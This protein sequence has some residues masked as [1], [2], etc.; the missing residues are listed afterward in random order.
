MVA[1][2]GIAAYWFLVVVAGWVLLDPVPLAWNPVERL[3]ASLLLGLIV[4][5]SVSFLLGLAI[6]ITPVT[7]LVAP[8]AIAVLGTLTRPGAWVRHFRTAWAWG[9]APLAMRVP[10]L[11]G[12]W[13]LAVIGFTGFLLWALFSRALKFGHG[14]LAAFSGPVWAD[15][16]LHLTI[17][18]SFYLGHHLP[19][20]NS[21]AS[22]SALHYPFLVDFQPALL[23]ALGQ[24][25]WGAL[26]MSSWLVAWAATTLIWYLAWRVLGSH[27]VGATVVLA[28]VLFGGGL[29]FIGLYGDGCQQVA[30]TTASLRPSDCTG[31]TAAA[32]ATVAKVAAH[33][34]A[35]LLHLPRFYDGE[36][37]TG[38]LTKPS[39]PN[40]QWYEPLLVYWLPQRDFAYGMGVV[41]LAASFL[42]AGIPTRK[43]RLVLAAGMAG[44]LLPLFNPFGYLVIGLVAAV[45]IAGAG[46]WRGLIIAGGPLLILGAWPLL[47]VAGGQHGALSGPGGPSLFPRVDIGWMAHVG[48]RCTAQQWDAGASCAS[49]YVPG[50]SPVTMLAFAAQSIAQPGLYGQ[51]LGFW[52]ANTGAFIPIALAGLVAGAVKIGSW[53]TGWRAL[54]LTTFAAPFWLVFLIANVVVTQPSAWNNTKLLQ[55]WYLGAA[56]TVGWLLVSVRRRWTRLGSAVLIGSL[57]ATGGLS[58]LVAVRGQ[59]SLSEGPLLSVRE[60]LAGAQTLQVAAAIEARTPSSA[61]FLTEGQPD[62]PVTAL[63]GRTSVLGF[64]G[65]LISY[66]QPIASRYRDVQTMYSGCPSHGRCAVGQLLRRYRVSYIEFEPRDYNGIHAN[67]TWYAAQHLNVIVKTPEYVIYAVRSLWARPAG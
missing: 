15:W 11:R 7:S 3:A 23:E 63:A 16:S 54:R 57:V 37:F 12:H 17:A 55:Y 47:L 8:V 9:R 46:W 49:L 32:P 30:T 62:D 1:H 6:G 35:E 21:L 52:L 41:A 18:Q 28:L 61:I 38:L 60:S 56:V 20:V 53:G 59:S 48:A 42:W 24:S 51:V 29:G 40:L 14:D 64:E 44:G 34:P 2:V 26:D 45:W 4:S 19:P 31:W 27:R 5:T 39:L 36:P 65:W 50:S 22:G 25:I 66:G 10:S 43:R 67:L 13:H 58:L 33:L